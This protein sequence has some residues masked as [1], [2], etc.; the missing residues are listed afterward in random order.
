[1]RQDV[2]ARFGESVTRQTPWLPRR[3]MMQQVHRPPRQPDGAARLSTCVLLAAN[4]TGYANL[5]RLITSG[6]LRRPK[7]ES[8]VT[9]PEVCERAEGLIALWGGERSLLVRGAEPRAVAGP[10]REAFGDRLYALAARHRRA[11]EVRREACLRRHAGRAGLPLVAATEV[12]YHTPARRDLQD[13]LTCIR[14]GVTLATA[15]RLIRPNAEH[16]LKSPQ[17]M[18]QLFADEPALRRADPRG[19][20]ALHLQPVRD[21][22]PLSRRAAA[23]RQDVVRLAARAHV[24]RRAR[25]L[26]RR[27]RR[28]AGHPRA[29]RPRAGADRRARLRRLLPDDVGDS[30]VLPAGGHPLPGARFGRQLGGLLLPGDHGGRPDAGRAAVRAVPVARAARA[31][32][33]R[34]RHHA[35]PPRG[36]DP[37]RLSQVRPRP[38][39]HGGQRRALPRALGGAGG[40][41]GARSVRDGDRPARPAPLALRPARRGGAGARRTR[42]GLAD[43]RSPLQAVR[44]DPGLSPP[45]LDPPGRLPARPRAGPRPGADRERHDARPDGDPVGQGRPGG[46]RPLQGRSAGARRA[47]P[48]RP[49]LPPA[50]PALRPRADA[51]PD[52]AR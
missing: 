8:R 3:P 38:R 37:A 48:A 29:D 4:R 26:R 9:W 11:E 17:R 34:P 44:A 30:P 20:V 39:R 36:G 45:S 25:A 18:A 22:L 1:M 47:D 51:R 28:A 35:R 2:P 14:H 15:G 52:P 5:C 10:L 6:R 32:G 50:R 19:G 23:R 7:G 13:V 43:P 31:A 49:G 27:R 41:Q 42:P 16:D 21:P 24:P 40:G 46:S 12:L 33:Y